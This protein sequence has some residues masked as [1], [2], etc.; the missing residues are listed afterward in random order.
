MGDTPDERERV[1]PPLA[2]KSGMFVGCQEY[3]Q[4]LP[5]LMTNYKATKQI[6]PMQHATEEFVAG[7]VA[8]D[9]INMRTEG[10][11]GS[12][13]VYTAQY[14]DDIVKHII[15]PAMD[16]YASSWMDN[17]R[18][19]IQDRLDYTM[20]DTALRKHSPQKRLPPTLYCMNSTG[21]CTLGGDGLTQGRGLTVDGMPTVQVGG[22]QS[23]N[24][25][26]WVN[27]QPITIDDTQDVRSLVSHRT[28]PP[29][30]AL[31]TDLMHTNSTIQT[32]RFSKRTPRSAEQRPRK[33]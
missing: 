29:Y 19:D 28:P 32:P 3:N 10:Y 22:S 25:V 16:T 31:G 24:R 11:E 6:N 8:S 18:A 2:D 21:M 12:H 20:L 14:T 4:L 15:Y 1:Y 26:E 23:F 33:S 27:Q 9:T 7:L 5:Q 17:I 13:P 30:L